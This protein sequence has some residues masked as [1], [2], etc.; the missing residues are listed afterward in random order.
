VSDD[1]R[2]RED[3][4]EYVDPKLR[5]EQAVGKLEGPGTPSHGQRH[6]QTVDEEG[7]PGTISVD[8][9]RTKVARVGTP[10]GWTATRCRRCMKNCSVSITLITG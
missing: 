9:G 6:S 7:V 8:R 5:H 4:V 2:I 1:L 10:R 3:M